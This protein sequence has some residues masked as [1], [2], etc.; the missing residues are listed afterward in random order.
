[1]FDSRIVGGVNVISMDNSYYTWTEEQ[2]K[3]LKLEVARGLRAGEGIYSRSLHGGSQA[4]Y[5]TKRGG[6]L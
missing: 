6:S 2:W 5:G 1:M 3:R 4:R